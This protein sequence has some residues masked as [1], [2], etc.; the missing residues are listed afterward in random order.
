MVLEALGVSKVLTLDLRLVKFLKTL[1]PI[2]IF[3]LLLILDYAVLGLSVV[4]LAF[5]FGILNLFWFVAILV[6]VV[7]KF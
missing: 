6:I 1:A 7:L 2:F 4:G 5:G 3:F